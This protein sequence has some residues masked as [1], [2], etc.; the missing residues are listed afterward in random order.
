[1]LFITFHNDGTGDEDTGNYDV[2][3]S[4]NGLEL[5]RERIE[6]HRRADGWRELVRCLVEKQGPD[7]GG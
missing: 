4:V 5:A 1:M 6:G 3:V 2:V 7:D